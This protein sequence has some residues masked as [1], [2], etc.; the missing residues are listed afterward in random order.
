MALIGATNNTEKELFE[1]LRYN[2]GFKNQQEVHL[3]MH[4]LINGWTKE[5]LP[6]TLSIANRV[7]LSK[8][9]AHK[10]NGEYTDKLKLHYN[11]EADEADFAND[12]SKILSM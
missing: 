4:K 10:V 6:F 1:C 8:S 2:V 3:F 11:A 12:E 9:E 5:D 7:L